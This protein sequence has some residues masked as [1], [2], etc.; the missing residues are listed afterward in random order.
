[1]DPSILSAVCQYVAV[2]RD[3]ESY[4]TTKIGVPAAR[5]THVYNGVDAQRF[6][7]AHGKRGPIDGGPFND[8]SLWVL[9]HVGRNDSVKDQVT[10]AR[11]FVR[12]LQIDP[13]QRVRLR[14]II[15]GDGPL[16][17]QV[18]KILEQAGVAD[19]TWLPGER[20]DIETIMRGFDCFV[21]P[22]LGEGISNTILEAMACGLPVIATNVGGNVELVQPGE[23][24]KLVAAADPEAM[25]RQILAY[26]RDPAAARRAGHAARARVERLF[27]LDAMLKRYVSLY[28]EQ[29][30]SAAL[31]FQRV[32]AA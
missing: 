8:P 5:V 23:T 6:R 27:S 18:Q 14:L 17:R 19:L 12:V 25:A 2:S 13:S 10:L 20:G 11:A 3:L 32:G 24:G 30:G 21:L 22:S 15:V 26:A 1:M 9:G 7:P 16:R 28:D 4:L 29:L 31:R